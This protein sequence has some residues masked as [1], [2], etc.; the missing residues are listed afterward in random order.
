MMI[1]VYDATE[2][3]FDNNGIKIL[4]PLKLDIYEEIN[5]D[6]Y[7]EVEDSIDN[8]DYYQQDYIIRVKT[9][10][11]GYQGF[12]IKNITKK[13]RKLSCKAWHLFY[14]SANY[15]ISDSYAFDK[16]CNAALEH[17]NAATDIASP[18]TTISDVTVVNSFRCVRKNLMEAVYVILERWGGCLV[19][20]NWNI[21]IK[22]DISQDRG[23][24]L[25]YGKNIQDIEAVENWDN[26]CT[27]ILPCTSDGQISITLD[28][29]YVIS[30]TKYDKAYSKVVS[31]ENKLEKIENETDEEYIS[32]IKED[33]KNKAKS[34]LEENKAPQVNYKVSSNIQDVAG[35]GDTIYVEHPKCDIAIVTQVISTK[36]DAI[37]NKY[38]S[39]EFGNFQKRLSNL[40]SEIT[41]VAETIA[42]EK[43]VETKAILQSELTDATNRINDVLGNGYVITEKNQILILDKLPKE[44]ATYVIKINYAGIGFSSTGINGIFN[45]AWNI[46][47]TLNMQ[48]INVINLTASMIKGGTLKLGSALNESGTFELYNSSNNLIGKMDKDGL[49][50]YANNGDKIKINPEVGFAGY[51]SAGIKVYWADG[52]EFHMKK[53]EVE[54]EITLASI[55]K[56]LGID[57]GTNKGIGLA[58]VV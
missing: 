11:R 35:I 32:R 26:V 29:V 42:N 44:N 52:D 7:I 57:N 43:T 16:N 54:Q 38:K 40:M 14:D 34:Y 24:T 18:F 56:W 9:P 22:Q 6:Y 10:N 55:G 30:D 23:V 58:P 3:L 31:F 2:K 17:F 47:G 15:L 13:N 12:R 27:K 48:Y 36:Y 49:E 39:I 28:D 37:S 33:L 50:M 19:R 5:G 21:E 20:D 45:S 1:R 41:N 4:H 25:K 51:N 8:I 46:D 53:S